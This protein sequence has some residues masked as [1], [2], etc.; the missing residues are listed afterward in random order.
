MDEVC[1]GDGVLDYDTLLLR[2]QQLDIDVTIYLEHFQTRQEFITALS[3]LE[4][5]AYR[6][7]V[8]FLRRKSTVPA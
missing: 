1:I 2:L 4:K 8:R 7:G 3:R 5:V 6:V